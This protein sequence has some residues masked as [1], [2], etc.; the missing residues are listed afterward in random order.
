MNDPNMTGFINVGMW[1]MLF[2]ER[3]KV[4]VYNDLITRIQGADWEGAMKMVPDL[5]W[6]IAFGEGAFEGAYYYQTDLLNTYNGGV[7]FQYNHLVKDW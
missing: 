4:V 3:S 7:P 6:G 1:G 2:P 5:F